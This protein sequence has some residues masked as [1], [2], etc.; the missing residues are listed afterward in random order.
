MQIKHKTDK[1]ELRTKN[2]FNLDEEK[3]EF[4]IGNRAL[5]FFA[6]QESRECCVFY[7]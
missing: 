3:I 4:A 6:G 1:Y 7:L 5:V 2:M